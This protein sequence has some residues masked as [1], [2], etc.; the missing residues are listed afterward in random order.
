ML[1]GSVVPI[2][3][4]GADSEPGDWLGGTLAAAIGFAAV[5]ALTVWQKRAEGNVP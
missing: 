3:P 5:Y 1:W 2:W 4:F